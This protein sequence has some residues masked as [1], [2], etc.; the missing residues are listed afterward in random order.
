[1]S[2]RRFLVPFK[3]L[4]AF[5]KGI[6]GEASLGRAALAAKQDFVRWNQQ[7]GDWKT[8]GSTDALVMKE[9]HAAR[10]KYA[11]PQVLQGKGPCVNND[12]CSSHVPINARQAEPAA[13]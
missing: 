3:V 1:M 9:V 7:Q 11:S 10:M 5:L 2:E 4:A 13:K 8:K 12:L 6:L